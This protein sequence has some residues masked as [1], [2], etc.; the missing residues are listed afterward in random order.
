MARG[1]L[2]SRLHDLPPVPRLCAARLRRSAP[3]ERPRRILFYPERPKP[4]AVVTAVCAERGWEIE[5]RPWWAF[6]QALRWQDRTRVGVPRV[7]ARIARERPVWN[8]GCTD[9]RKGV[10]DG[11]FERVFGR[12][13]AV[14]PTRHV[15]PMVEKSE[16]NGRHDG[17]VIEGPVARPRRG[18]Y[19][20]RVV[21]NRVSEGVVEDLRVVVVGD[22]IPVVYTKRRP[23]E[24]RFANRNLESELLEA[25]DVLSTEEREA[26]LRLSAGIRLDL[27]ELDVLR[28]RAD[29]RIWVV[30]VA[31]TPFGP[32]NHIPPEQGREAV[33]RI[34]ESLARLPSAERL[35]HSSHPVADAGED[36]DRDLRVERPAARWRYNEA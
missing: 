15:G 27:G 2:V 19:Y 13:L 8:L 7:L 10:V 4:E 30:D 1:P 16:A 11:A 34:G 23:L 21:D 17:R 3:A 14:D 5:H 18:A 33:A 6:D 36:A 9:I 31:N 29:G 20:S 26:L 35:S 25:G 12:S 28:D 32:P 24:T 22:E